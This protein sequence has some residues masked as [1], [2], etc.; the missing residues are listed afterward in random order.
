MTSVGKKGGTA[1]KAKNQAVDVTDTPEA[2]KAAC[3]FC[4]QPDLKGQNE[5]DKA[6]RM[7]KF[8]GKFYHY[9]CILFR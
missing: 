4:H 7:F 1:K 8:M 5:I 9:F 3:E 6:G 2:A